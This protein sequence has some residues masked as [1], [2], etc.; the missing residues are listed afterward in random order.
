MDNHVST[1]DS[2]FRFTDCSSSA[3]NVHGILYFTKLQRLVVR[4]VLQ[5][6]WI[7]RSKDSGTRSIS[8]R[9]ETWRQSDIFQ[10]QSFGSSL[11]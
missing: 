2:L 1:E 5:L 6:Q 8:L 7:M 11:V 3:S 4:P 9:I 10:T